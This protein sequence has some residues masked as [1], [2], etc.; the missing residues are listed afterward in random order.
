MQ[1]NIINGE[2]VNTEKNSLVD[3]LT[4]NDQENL[5]ENDK[6]R[7]PSDRIMRKIFDVTHNLST[8]LDLSNHNLIA[9]PEEILEL[10]HLQNLYLNGNRLST[11]PSNFFDKLPNLQWL[12]L[13][14]NELKSIPSTYIGRHKFLRNL[15]LEGNN[16]RTLPLELGLINTMNGLNLRDN[17]L[18]F[19]PAEVIEKGTKEILKFF[20][21]ILYAK[22]GRKD[23]SEG[24]KDSIN[25][26]RKTSI[27]S[28]NDS[29]SEQ[30]QQRMHDDRQLSSGKTRNRST[31]IENEEFVGP[32]PKPVDLQRKGSSK[33]SLRSGGSRS[34]KSKSRQSKRIDISE[35]IED[36]EYKDS[37]KR[38]QKLMEHE[39][40]LA[41][42]RGMNEETDRILQKRR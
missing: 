38:L 40:R 42:M 9:I 29:T 11:L 16:L 34:G 37:D 7:L 28:E 36:A 22:S 14:F 13:R 26:N 23:P 24:S 15:L 33:K 21:E 12:D 41:L 39:R 20:K 30:L 25:N 6:S 32:V 3:K 2:E 17:P 27:S 4:L 31:S 5:D 8:T 10:S 35:R 19:P 1:D 18:E